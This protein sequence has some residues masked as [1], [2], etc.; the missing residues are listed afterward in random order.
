M[1]FQQLQAQGK[2]PMLVPRRDVQA[3]YPSINFVDHKNDDPG[4]CEVCE[5]T[6]GETWYCRKCVG[7]MCAALVGCATAPFAYEGLRKSTHVKASLGING[8]ALQ[9]LEGLTT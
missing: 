9:D 4:P 1:L 2:K 7:R 8:S 5:G 6:D 3:Q